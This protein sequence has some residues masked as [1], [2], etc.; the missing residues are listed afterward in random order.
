MTYHPSF[1]SSLNWWPRPR[2]YSHLLCSPSRGVPMYH[3]ISA[4]Q[5]ETET[6]D[7]K[8]LIIE[9]PAIKTLDISLTTGLHKPW[10]GPTATDPNPPRLPYCSGASSFSLWRTVTTYTRL[11]AHTIITIPI[12]SH[13]LPCTL[14]NPCNHYHHQ[15]HL[16]YYLISQDTIQ[17]VKRECSFPLCIKHWWGVIQFHHKMAFVNLDHGFSNWCHYFHSRLILVEHNDKLQRTF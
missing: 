17:W 14:T 2:T 8:D 13:K 10:S 16:V 6:L 11:H 4:P 3:V 9:Y 5:A 1:I 12:I 15:S 7:H